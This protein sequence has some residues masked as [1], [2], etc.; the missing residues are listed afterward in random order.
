MDDFM[1]YSL[2]DEIIKEAEDDEAGGGEETAAADNA[3]TNGDGEVSDDEANAAATEEGDAADEEFDVDTDIPEGDD[4]GGDDAGDDNNND[5]V[6]TSS[7]PPDT[8]PASDDEVKPANT[9]IFD[10][11][12]AEEQNI[13][14]KELKKSYQNLYATI[15]DILN[16]INNMDIDEDTLDVMSRVTITL[17]NL[18]D[19][20]ANYFI[21]I[22]NLRSYLENDIKF[23]EFLAILKAVTVVV[24]ELS[25]KKQKI[26]GLDTTKSDKK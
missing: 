22:F 17:C 10:T 11:L 20:L 8:S 9:N 2:F 24:D 18:K 25:S 12:T 15:D 16:R 7:S 19:E 5:T 4:E 26:I 1:K 23:N 21:H 6:D 3:D 13:K 14:I